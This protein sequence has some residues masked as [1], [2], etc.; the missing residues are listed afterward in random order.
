MDEIQLPKSNF[1]IS[2]FIVCMNLKHKM[3][4]KGCFSPSPPIKKPPKQCIHP[5]RHFIGEME[6]EKRPK[7]MLIWGLI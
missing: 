7:E 1:D 5:C 6:E 4:K 3:K 2:A